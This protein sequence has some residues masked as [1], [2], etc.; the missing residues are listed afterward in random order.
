M[1]FNEVR[2]FARADEERS[3]EASRA[4]AAV[5]TPPDPEVVATPDAAPV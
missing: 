2:G 3:D 5:R 4:P 1:N